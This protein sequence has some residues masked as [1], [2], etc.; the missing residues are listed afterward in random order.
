MRGSFWLYPAANVGHVV[1]AATLFGMILAA[2][3]RLL[4]L[5][6]ALP[7]DAVLRFT[8]PWAWAGFALAAAT[9][10]LLFAADPLE[11]AANPFFRIKLALL[12]IAGAQH[13]GVPADRAAY[14]PRAPGE[15]RPVDRGLARRPGVRAQHRLLVAARAPR[16]G[17]DAFRSLQPDVRHGRGRDDRAGMGDDARG[18]PVAE[19]GGAR[20]ARRR[21][22]APRD[23]RH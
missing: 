14:R 3:L 9:G 21:A 12:L 23:S 1:G 22:G 6:R 4:G 20:A 11:I 19:A 8:L 16:T 15:R 17:G 5:G 18:E 13:A 2:D 7:A 10:P